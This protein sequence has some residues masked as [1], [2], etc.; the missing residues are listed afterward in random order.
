MIKNLFDGRVETTLT[1]EKA[2]CF[3]RNTIDIW[4]N[5]NYFNQQPC[6]FSVE[7]ASLPEMNILYINQ[8]YQSCKDNKKVFYADYFLV[9]QVNQCLNPPEDLKNYKCQPNEPKIYGPK[10]DTVTGEFVGLMETLS[11]LTVRGDSGECFFDYGYS[12][13]KSKILYSNHKMKIPNSFS[14][15]CSTRTGFSMNL[16]P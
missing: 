14:G 2:A 16:V 4:K 3:K 7:K 9:G 12:K 11:Y 13:E 8:A 15:M 6:Q 10:Y 1:A 5:Y